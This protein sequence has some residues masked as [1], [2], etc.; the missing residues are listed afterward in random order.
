M[1]ALLSIRHIPEQA[2]L[3]DQDAEAGVA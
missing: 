3:P 2:G 1:T